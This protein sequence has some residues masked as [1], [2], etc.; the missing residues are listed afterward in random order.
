MVSS[1]RPAHL[2]CDYL[3]TPLGIDTTQPRLSWELDSPHRAQRQT[4]YRILVA[5]SSATLAYGQADLWDSG[6]VASSA[7]NQIVYSG[8]P[9]HSRQRCWWSVQVWDADGQPSLIATSWWEMGLLRVSD[10][11]GTWITMVDLPPSPDDALPAL[12]PSP[13]LRKPFHVAK[14]V[15]QARLYAT[16]RGLYSAH[17]NGQRVGTALLTPGWTDYHTRIQYQTYDVTALVQSGPNLLGAVLGT[18]WHAGYVGFNSG[19][20]FYGTDPHLL[21]QLVIT[22]SDGSHEIIATD[23][24]W[25]ASIGPILFSDLL[26]GESYDAR[27]A[28][29][30]WDTSAFDASAWTPVRSTP[31]ASEALV[32]DRAEPVEV[33]QQRPP[34]TITA[35]P[36]GIQIVD[37][38]QN[39]VGWV[40]LHAQADAGT[41]VRL[42]FAE[43]LNPDGSLYTANLRSARQTDVFTLSGGADICEPHFTFHGF[44]YVE[45]S[46]YPG[47]LSPAAITGV[48]VGSATPESGQLTTS[49]DLVNQ[50]Q[51][52]IV[53][54]QRGNF[55]SVP[56]DCPQRDER[57][58]WTGD[59][60]IFVGT[61]CWNADVAA[62]FSKWMIDLTDAQAEDGAFP[63]IAPCLPDGRLHRGAPAWG[64]AGVIVP[65]TLYTM[66]GDI[67]LIE[68]H[69][70]A[71]A[72]WI[73]FIDTAN[74]DHIWRN[75]RGPDFGDWLAL[76]TAS[77]SEKF[78]SGT[79]ND[80]LATA[81]FAYDT[82]LLARMADAIGRT[83]DAERYRAL[84]DQIVSAFHAE[85]VQPD[86]RLAGDTQTAYA[87]AL[88]MDLLSPDLR[89]LAGEHLART[90][91]ERDGHLSTGFVGVGYLCPALTASGRS[92]LAYDLLVKE[93]FP[94]WGYSIRHGATTIW[95]R[96]DGWTAERGFQDVGMNSFNHY[97]L[98]SV[99]QWM[100]EHMAGIQPASPGFA[101]IRI[102]PQIGAPLR[103]VA[104]VY[105]S[106]RG[107]IASEWRRTDDTLALTVHI[108]ANTT[109]EI[110]MPTNDS[111]SV[112]ES[113]QPASQ[114][115]GV[116]LLRHEPGH[117]I[118][119]VASGDYRFASPL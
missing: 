63:N 83:A 119:S 18:G 53:W 60:Q 59:A 112:T 86:G 73:S 76:D 47:P 101:A 21:A 54:G 42:R 92:D 94:S 84:R 78:V 25:R 50:L 6:P 48:V 12:R 116:A 32:A 15:A 117:A 1:L 7:S 75:Q 88:F 106:L 110:W 31:L 16:A 91:A 87:L 79:P 103:Q 89:R 95:E 104:A 34:Q 17:I 62:F 80:L 11:Q 10:W 68:R 8:S 26:M 99:G 96:W 55:L 39:M 37:M 33:L 49:H 22:Y 81:Y 13:Y 35:R 28:L 45:V 24:T 85:F 108:P 70:D 61:A 51:S 3:A 5:S 40:R 77:P 2:R 57:L 36:D 109:A 66:Y 90:L 115:E 43:M 30:G 52:N 72:H 4:S 102:H 100:Y 14:P 58:G 114:A 97:S 44:R 113:G 29:T 9:L 20:S 46:G 67:R 105:R 111:A 27:R 23:S 69:Y 118:Y 56:T 19:H 71:M 41:Q 38:G 64:D 74:P 93:T 107:P 98:G 65:W 82:G